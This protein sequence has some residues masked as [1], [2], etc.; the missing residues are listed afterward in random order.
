MPKVTVL[1]DNTT[2]EVG[3][4]IR[5]VTACQATTS[6]PFGSEDGQ[7]VSCIV[8]VVEGAEHVCAMGAGERA[9]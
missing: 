1:K 6:I 4:G 3:V 5:P 2:I 7:C 8:Q 9:S